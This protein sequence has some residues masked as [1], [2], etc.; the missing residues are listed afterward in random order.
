MEYFQHAE[1]SLAHLLSQRGRNR[2]VSS[3]RHVIHS[4]KKA[5]DRPLRASRALC[6]HLLRLVKLVDLAGLI[7]ENFDQSRVNLLGGF[8]GF[9]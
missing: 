7:L 3:P 5:P 8:G 6:V 1:G 2:I 9:P 4:I